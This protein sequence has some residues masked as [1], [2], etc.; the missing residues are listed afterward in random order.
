MILNI[1]QCNQ[2]AKWRAKFTEPSPSYVKQITRIKH[3]KVEV[4]H[5]TNQCEP[6]HQKNTIF[7]V[8]TCMTSNFKS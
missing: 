6:F 7:D 8:D 3:N 2:L 1:Q 4:N 5:Y